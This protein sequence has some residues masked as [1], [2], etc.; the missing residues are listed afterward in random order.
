MRELHEKASTE[1]E[2]QDKIRQRRIAIT[3]ASRSNPNE[4]HI[5]ILMLFFQISIILKNV[6]YKC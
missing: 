5:N 6:I 4:I 1:I 3:E 2:K